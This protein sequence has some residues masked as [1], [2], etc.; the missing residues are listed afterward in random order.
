MGSR[1][2]LKL[3]RHLNPVTS[4]N[5]AGT[6]ADDTAPEPPDRPFGFPVDDAELSALWDELVPVLDRAGLLASVDGLTIELALRHFLAAR[7]ASD[8]LTSTGVVVEDR[9]HAGVQRKSPAGAEFR[10]QST[11]FLEYAKQL[12]MSFVARARVPS[13]RDSDG[14]EGNPFATQTG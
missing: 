10:S 4:A 14:G 1:G 12:G 3:P 6:M 2:P 7:R 8:A 9:A 13:Q 5:A 11:L